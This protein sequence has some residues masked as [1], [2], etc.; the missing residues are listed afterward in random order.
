MIEV[1][2]KPINQISFDDIESLITLKVPES[3]QIEFKETLPAKNKKDPWII[4]ESEVGDYA[5]NSILREVVAFANAYGGT[6]LLGIKESDASPSVATGI[7]PIPR[8]ADLAERL[9][10]VFRDR[11]E[12]QL[13]NLEIFVVPI[14]GDSGVTIIRTSRSYRAPHRIT[15]MRVCPVRRLDRCDE[16]SMHEIKDTTL[17]LSRGLERLE[18]KLLGRAEC[19][20]REVDYFRTPTNLLEAFG[21]RLTAAPVLDEVRFDTVLSHGRLSEELQKPAIKVVRRAKG[22]TKTL[23][24]LSYHRL[25]LHDWEP[26]LRSARA[27]N[28]GGFRNET[29]RRAYGEVHCDGLIE[30][31]FVSRRSIRHPD[32]ER[33]SKASLRAEML[34]FMFADLVAWADQI[35]KQAQIPMAEYAIEVEIGAIG[36]GVPVKFDDGDQYPSEW[37]SLPPGSITFPRYS[38]TD[39][40]ESSRLV[41]LFERDFWN[42]VGRDFKESQGTLEIEFAHG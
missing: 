39:A 36:R 26:R 29:D 24:G 30:M 6:L 31:G 14:E 17:N 2:S 35:R 16:M 3:E 7:S 21:F 33:R 22:D 9:K 28:S 5:K 25:S 12:P 8:C 37:G 34:V 40:E 41:S 23:P 27:V 38:F 42:Y 4:G 20:K 19:F 18:K 32:N 13:S 15:G 11:V 10:L 1:L